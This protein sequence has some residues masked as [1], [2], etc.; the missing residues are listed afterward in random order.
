MPENTLPV[1]EKIHA[2]V[3]AVLRAQF[4]AAADTLTGDSEFVTA[5]P[6]GFDSLTALD[7]ISRVE[8]AFGLEVDFVSHD[9]RYW[10]VTPDRIVRYVTDQLED[11]AVLGNTR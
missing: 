11:R 6:T 3:W 2:E 10:F 1:A 5:L 7:T 8:A 4:G 9:V